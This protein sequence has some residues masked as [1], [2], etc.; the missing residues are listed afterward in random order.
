METVFEEGM[1]VYDEVFFPQS[2][3]RVIKVENLLVIVCFEC[4]DL[5]VKADY[6]KNGRLVTTH[7]RTKPTLSTSCYKFEGF[8]QK[9]NITYEKAAEWVDKNVKG[10]VVYADEIY[11]DEEH[12]NAFEALK[13]LIVLREY[14][15]NGWRPDWD[16]K[17]FKKYVIVISYDGFAFREYYDEQSVL[18]FKT[19]AV[20]QRFF[21][22][23]QKLLK[24]AKPLL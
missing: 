18:I 22:E 21:N 19:P 14:Y 24:I 8:E 1:E 7:E 10:R 12:K 3:G 6:T 15:N 2:K 16:D 17:S 23:Q 13:K 4:G 5:K 9:G 11:I 20:R